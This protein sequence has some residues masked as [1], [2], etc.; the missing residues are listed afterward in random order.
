M[1][2]TVTPLL[3]PPAHGGSVGTTL[4]WRAP[5]LREYLTRTKTTNGPAVVDDGR[6]EQLAAA[7][8][9][10]Q[11]LAGP[12]GTSVEGV[13]GRLLAVQAQ[14]GRGRGLASAAGR[15]G[16]RPPMSTRR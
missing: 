1:T 8:L 7:R 16:L 6:D 4:L 13:V 14:D 11:M 2:N 12:P 5:G 9:A 3:G 15:R 10:S